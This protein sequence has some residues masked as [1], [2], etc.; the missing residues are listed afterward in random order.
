MFSVFTSFLEVDYS[1]PVLL[2]VRSRS[3]VGLF[4]CVAM[5]LFC[6]HLHVAGSLLRSQKLASTLRQLER[7]LLREHVL[8]LVGN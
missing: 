5:L 7:R 6:N 4:I 8:D 1:N 2:L 3:L